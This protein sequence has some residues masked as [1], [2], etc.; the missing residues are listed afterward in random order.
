MVYP[1]RIDGLL[2]VH[3]MIY[4]ID[5]DL[6]HCID[7]PRTSARAYGKPDRPVLTQHNG[8]RHRGK[9]SLL[10]NNTVPLALYHSPKIRRSGP[11]CKVIHLVVQENAGPFG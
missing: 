11:G 7:D 5:D 9:R 4:D 1:R 6:H 3:P 8:W 2:D 10:W